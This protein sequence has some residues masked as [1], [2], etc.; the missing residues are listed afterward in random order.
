MKTLGIDPGTV[1]CGYCV[2]Q[3]GFF[4]SCGV[5]HFDKKEPLEHEIHR[6][7][8]CLK[9]AYGPFDIVGIERQMKA[10]MRVVQTHLYHEFNPV[11]KIVAPQTVKRYFNFSGVKCYKKRKEKGV[12]IMKQLCRECKQMYIFEKVIRQRS[13]IDDVADGALIAYYIYTEYTKVKKPKKKKNDISLNDWR[14]KHLW[15][16]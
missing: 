16:V 15:S 9:E 10:K 7:A 4:L 13:K 14:N 3:D 2:I 1:N 12:E 8:K 11:S 5:A 6:F